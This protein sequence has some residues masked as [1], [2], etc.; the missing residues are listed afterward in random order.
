MNGPHL[1]MTKEIAMNDITLCISSQRVNNAN[2]ATFDF[3][4]VSTHVFKEIRGTYSK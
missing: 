2:L 4:E 3:N 1:F